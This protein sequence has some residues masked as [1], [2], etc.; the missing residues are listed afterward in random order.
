MHIEEQNQAVTSTEILP[1]GDSKPI[2][3]QH[4]GKRR[5]AGRKPDISRQREFM[6]KFHI[7]SIH[8]PL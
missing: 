5:G 1:Q 6:P 2:K 4:G 7:P 3:K 8:L